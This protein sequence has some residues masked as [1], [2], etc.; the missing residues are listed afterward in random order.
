MAWTAW[1][2]LDNTDRVFCVVSVPLEE[3]RRGAGTA[4]VE[5]LADRLRGA[6]RTVLYTWATCHPGDLDAGGGALGFARAVRAEVDQMA[7]FEVVALVP[8]IVLRV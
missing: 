1:P 5:H 8:V 4:I 3:R 2:L 6:G 7:I